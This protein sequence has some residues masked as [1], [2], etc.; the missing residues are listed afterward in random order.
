MA[1][2]CQQQFGA[3]YTNLRYEARGRFAGCLRERSRSR[4]TRASAATDGGCSPIDFIRSNT[5]IGP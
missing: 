1:S 3:G 5:L 2:S 4:N